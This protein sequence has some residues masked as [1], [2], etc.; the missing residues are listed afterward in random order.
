MAAS[1]PPYP[2][3]PPPLAAAAAA[4]AVLVLVLEQ[5]CQAAVG[6]C[7]AVVTATGAAA[8]ISMGAGPTK[9]R[10]GAVPGLESLEKR[11]CVRRY[12]EAALC[13]CVR[14]KLCMNIRAPVK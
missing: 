3:P 7:Q 2:L 14:T 5:Q 11:W 8:V 10:A 4:A 9:V 13:L 6:V 12:T 1:Q